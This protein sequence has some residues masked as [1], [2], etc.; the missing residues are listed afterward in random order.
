MPHDSLEAKRQM[1]RE[2]RAYY[3]ND[4]IQLGQIHEFQ[5]K[6]QS[7]D[8][9]HWYTKPGFL[10][11]LVNKAL[12]SQ[13]IWALYKFRYFIMDLSCYLE[14]M[15]RSQSFSTI[16]LY[17]GAKLNRNEL[18]QLQVGSL[19]ST[20]G[21]LSCSSNR[22]VAEMF[23]D[24][25]YK[26]NSSSNRTQ[27][28][29][30]QFVLFIIDVDY[31]T[32]TDIVVA[33][34][35]RDSD[36]PDEDE[37]LF[38]FGSTFIIN[39]I[40]LDNDK[41]I[42]LIEMSSSSDHARINEGYEQYIRLRLQHISPMIML[43]HILANIGGD[44]GQ[45]MN[46]FH[47]LLKILPIDHTERPNVY[48][49]LANIYRFIEKFDKSL[50]CFRCARLLVR[51]FLPER[52]FDYCRILD[53]MGTIYSNLGHSERAI[54][55]FEQVSVL[56]KKSFPDNHS[57]IPFHLN[58]MGHCLYRAKQYDRALSILESSKKFF[59]DKM[60]IEL[61]GYAQ[62][63]HIMGLVYRA[64]GDDNEALIAFQEAARRR[65][66]LLGKEHPHLALT[67]YQLGLLHSD[68]AE[69]ELALAYVE[70]SLNIQLIKLPHCHSETKLSRELLRRIHQNQFRE[71]NST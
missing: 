51:R 55:L 23:I 8:V 56:Q 61:Q 62:T 48:Y 20:N 60:P 67:Y 3:R 31:T 59:Q 64:L 14:K 12:R 16:R 17:R 58:L 35:S 46:Y 10:Y 41:G 29:W 33:D 1:L 13:D 71:L 30:Q 34:I 52:V 2:C 6:Y 9:I 28:A 43:G 5:R 27:D 68:R 25:D 45:W 54:M 69:Y 11:Y 70:K 22:D 37:M 63:L 65:Y 66:S 47:R 50:H 38:N 26:N 49:V 44:L 32:S 24:T 21:F 7:K 19:I 40:C 39:K 53:G 36:I 42:W 4:P 15:S 57:E 18:K